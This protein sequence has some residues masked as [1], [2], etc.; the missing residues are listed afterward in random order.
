MLI[1]RFQV[2]GALQAPWNMLT[3]RHCAYLEPFTAHARVH[4]LGFR[5]EWRALL[6]QDGLTDSDLAAGQ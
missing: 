6:W 3:M 5:L 4:I 2:F 1:P